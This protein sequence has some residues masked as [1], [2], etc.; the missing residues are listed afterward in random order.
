MRYDSFS[1]ERYVDVV[2]V[3]SADVGPVGATVDVGVVHRPTGWVGGPDEALPDEVVHPVGGLR[4]GELG[5][6]FPAAGDVGG[7][8]R[9]E[10]QVAGF[11]TRVIAF[12]VV[13]VGIPAA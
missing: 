5:G 11:P 13:Q 10:E 9:V 7:V 8:V 3:A 2:V 4:R 6:E 1:I 12:G